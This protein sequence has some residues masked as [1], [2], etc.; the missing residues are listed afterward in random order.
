MKLLNVSSLLMSSLLC[1]TACGVDSDNT[2]DEIDTQ[3]ETQIQSE[4]GTSTQTQVEV[5]TQAPVLTLNGE[6]EIKLY[7]GT[8]YFE[9]GA[10]VTDNID[11]S[12]VPV[13]TSN[14][15]DTQIGSYSVLYT[16]TDASGN[17]A[18]ITRWVTV[19]P[20]A[21]VTIWK[22]DNE[23]QSDDNQ[24]TIELSELFSYDFNV[25]WGD[26]E[27]NNNVTSEITHT[28]SQAG[29][30]QVII[31][32]TYPQIYFNRNTS[33]NSDSRKLLS[34]EHWGSN[35]WQSMYQA[36]YYAENME[37]NT[38][39]VPDLSSVTSMYRMFFGASSLNQDL[40]S[41][42]VSS[43]TNMGEMFYGASSFNHDLSSWDVSSV[44][45]MSDM[46]NG[47]SSFDQDLISWN[48][49]SV[50]NMYRMFYNASSFNQDLS[51]WDVSS[52]ITMSDMFSGASNF[53]QDL[54]NWDVS[55]VMEM[56]SMFRSAGSFNQ[57]LSGWDVS[58]VTDIYKM[59]YDA[60]TFNQELNG[61]DVSS[62]TRMDGMF[63]GA[64]NFN[65]DLSGWDVS[66]VRKMGGM[67][68]G[69]TSFN[70]DLSL[71]DVSSVTSMGGV[72]S[73]KY[74]MFQGATS[75]DQDVSMWDI[76]SVT[77]MGKL[78]KDVTLSTPNY[79]A[80]LAGWSAQITPKENVVFDGG[81]STYT[82]GSLADTGR[83]YLIDT[84][85]WSIADGGAAVA[86]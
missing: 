71:W 19:L 16:A 76:T 82:P 24:L 31:T 5:D 48:V 28:Y 11:E 33:P 54:S 65:Q 46:F 78:F 3:S 12:T 85:G 43:V 47:V 37:M 86:D 55:S 35:V 8:A 23:G 79:D 25:D 51:G 4:T 42:D 20:D 22:T 56:T 34:V 40:N 60:S 52:V 64:T 14:V 15:D 73:Y 13:I 62:V 66:S 81:N 67:F 32:G 77:N 9:L 6:P 38:D 69:A 36:F 83:T 18:S 63:Y 10:N 70:Q 1:L 68:S 39:D 2:S 59:F 26:G 17:Q 50:E 30:Y 45:S 53:N 41:W 74:G 75:F 57:D 84:L 7:L 58:S 49:S 80:L 61:W 27:T 72:E 29:E 21:F 44:R